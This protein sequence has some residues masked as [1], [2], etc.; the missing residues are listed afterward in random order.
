MSMEHFLRTNHLFLTGRKG[1]GKS[2]LV[3]KLLA[4]YQGR[5]GGFFT[6]KT[7]CVVPGQTTVHLLRA[8]RNEIPSRENLLFCCGRRDQSAAG[9]FDVLGCAALAIPSPELWVMD[10]LGPHEE[11]A[12]DFCRVVEA[13]LDGPVPVIGVLQQADAAF[14]RRVAAH[15]RVQVV[16]VTE[17]NRDDLARRF[18]EKLN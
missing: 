1:V 18:A 7:Q 4:T 2:T 3:R 17:E 10:E 15:P 14:L 12:A 13:I 5:L 8:D 16:E 6:V 11:Q 9:R